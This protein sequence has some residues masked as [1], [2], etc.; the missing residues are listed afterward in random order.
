LYFAFIFQKP[1]AS[2]GTWTDR[3]APGNT[4][5][6]GHKAG[7]YVS[8][9]QADDP[10]LMKVGIS[11]V[12]IANAEEN[13]AKEIPGW[14][15]DA[16]QTAAKAAWTKALDKVQ[17]EGGTPEQRTIFYTGVYHMLLS[18]NIFS[19]ENGDY[20]GFD[21]KV[22]RLPPGKKQFAN[23]SDWDIY[24]NTIQ[25]QALLYPEQ[26]SQMMQSLVH[27]P[28]RAAGCRAGRRPTTTATSWE[29]T[30]RRSCCRKGMH[31]GREILT[32]S[33]R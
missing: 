25:L 11:F 10:I 5:A 27:V 16:V 9:G 22:R 2:S 1:F 17:A 33:R 7:A 4:S 31:S 14:D 6:T 15:F 29:A 13:L 24:R 12:S 26:T 21:W 20:T 28:S 8:F 23:F 32:R 18:P 30:R 3:I 19:D